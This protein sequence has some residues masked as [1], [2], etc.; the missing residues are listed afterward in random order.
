MQEVWSGECL[1]G[2][3]VSVAHCVWVLKAAVMAGSG[4]RGGNMLGI[5]VDG[6]D[7]AL[8][9]LRSRCRCMISLLGMHSYDVRAGYLPGATVMHSRAQLLL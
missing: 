2:V 9:A 3:C 4:C 5:T 1:M 6:T 8:A 7:V